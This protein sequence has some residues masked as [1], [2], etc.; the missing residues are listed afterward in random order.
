MDNRS[1]IWMRFWASFGNE[2][3]YYIYF[4]GFKMPCF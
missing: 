3:D 2:N 1:Q 4:Q